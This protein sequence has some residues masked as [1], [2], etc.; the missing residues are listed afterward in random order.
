MKTKHTQGE[1]KVSAGIEIR[2]ESGLLIAV[3]M[4]HLDSNGVPQNANAK[5][6]AEAPESI[7]RLYKT[8]EYL[9]SLI[10]NECIKGVG[11]IA[12]IKEMIFAN[13]EQIKKATE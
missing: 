2:T 6:I 9:K 3:M 13:D 5:L 8:N 7:F 1:W 12:T 10:D 4:K 11:T